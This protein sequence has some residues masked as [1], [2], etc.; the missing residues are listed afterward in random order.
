MG[1]VSRATSPRVRLWSSAV[2]HAPGKSQKDQ[3]LT[4]TIQSNE[5]EFVLHEGDWK[6]QYG[7]A[8]V[9]KARTD[10]TAHSVPREGENRATVL[11]QSRY[12][13]TL[14]DLQTT[15]P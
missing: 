3:A 4:R 15:C 13:R 10:R 12:L 7:K 2:G 6:Q 5:Q 11:L 1:V 14:H 9:A 8:K